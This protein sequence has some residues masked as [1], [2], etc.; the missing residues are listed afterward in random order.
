[1]FLLCGFILPQ[2]NLYFSRLT[3]LYLFDT[4]YF[5]ISHLTLQIKLCSYIIHNIR[6]QV[7]WDT[8]S[9][10]DIYKWDSTTGKFQSTCDII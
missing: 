1:M 3:I 9:E 7:T 6:G 5:L 8:S 10:T 2:T 4:N